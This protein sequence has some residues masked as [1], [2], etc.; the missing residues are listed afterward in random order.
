MPPNPPQPYDWSQNF[1]LPPEK[2]KKK[3]NLCYFYFYYHY[4]HYHYH[5]HYHYHHYSFIYLFIF[6]I[7]IYFPFLNGEVGK[8]V[9]HS[10]TLW[11]ITL[12]P[13]LVI[14]KGLTKPI[15]FIYLFILNG[16]W[17]G[18][19]SRETLWTKTLT[20][21]LVIPKGLTRLIYSPKYYSCSVI[22]APRETASQQL[23]H[24]VQSIRY[25]T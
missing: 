6:F 21:L 23:E 18:R 25:D 9:K 11:T 19:E 14:P 2:K 15:L 3:K 8:V 17:R 20:P 5:Y 10:E 7:F 22:F 16:Q 13:L 24:A 4:H 1:C 12:T